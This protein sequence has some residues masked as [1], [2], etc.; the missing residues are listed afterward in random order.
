MKSD[1]ALKTIGEVSKLIDVPQHVIR[2]WEKKFAHLKP[3]Q[4]EKGR[5]YYSQST[6]KELFVLKDLLYTQKYSIKGAQKKILEDTTK[7]EPNIELQNL[8]GEIEFL[9]SEMNKYF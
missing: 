8:I 2:F 1:T 3:I 5:R 4:K 6:L 7:K 9:K